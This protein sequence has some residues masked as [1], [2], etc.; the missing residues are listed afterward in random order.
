M[1]PAIYILFCLNITFTLIVIV[2]KGIYFHYIF[3]LLIDF[4]NIKVTL[5]PCKEGNFPIHNGTFETFDCSSFRLS[6]NSSK[7]RLYAVYILN[8]KKGIRCES[9]C[10]LKYLFFIFGCKIENFKVSFLCSV[11]YVLLL[12]I[13]SI[14]LYLNT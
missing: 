11:K 12:N 4:K 5:R 7:L 9:G 6:L 2:L 8:T 10:S 3:Y 13:Y 14:S 1:N